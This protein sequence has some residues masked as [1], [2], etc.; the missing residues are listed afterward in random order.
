MP[1][2]PLVDRRSRLLRE[3]GI[4][5]DKERASGLFAVTGAAL[6]LT[7]CTFSVNL[8]PAERV[9]DTTETRRS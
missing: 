7:A 8:T 3:P 9:A 6:L 2:R 5:I 4:D 1:P